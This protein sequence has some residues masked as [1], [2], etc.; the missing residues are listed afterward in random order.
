[1]AEAILV[2]DGEP[3]PVERMGGRITLAGT[4]AAST[5]FTVTLPLYSA[6]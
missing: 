3:A 1:M 6:P 5:V 4:A 2:A